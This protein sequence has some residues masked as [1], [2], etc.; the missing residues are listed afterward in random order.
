MSFPRSKET[1]M[2]K[3][4]A[5][6][7][8]LRGDQSVTDIA[9]QQW[10][11]VCWP[12][13]DAFPSRNENFPEK[14]EKFANQV[15]NFPIQIEVFNT[16]PKR[17]RSGQT[18]KEG[19]NRCRCTVF[20]RAL[21]TEHDCQHPALHVTSSRCNPG[22]KWKESCNS[23][24]CLADGTPACT[25]RACRRR[26]N[27]EVRDDRQ[28]QV[29]KRRVIWDVGSKAYRNANDVRNEW[30]EVAAESGST[31]FNHQS[32]I[33]HHPF[34]STH[35]P[36]PITHYKRQIKK[37]HLKKPDE[38]V[39]E[40]EA[41]TVR[42]DVNHLPA[43]SECDVGRPGGGVPCGVYLGSGRTLGRPVTVRA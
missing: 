10:T 35:Q 27:S 5:R 34:P 21:C 7:S 3:R 39:A 2:D 12:A 40:T 28:S 32:P 9:Y 4:A 13:A 1:Q 19:C 14:V 20:G 8:P 22:E 11:R 6:T 36:S 29:R 43:S 37:F 17:C 42:L 38:K 41:A 33:T 16:F 24:T 30:L 31:V 25:R 26:R 23:C 18:W 15:Q